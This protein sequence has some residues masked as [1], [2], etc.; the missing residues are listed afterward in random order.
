MGSKSR[1]RAATFAALTL[2][3]VMSACAAEE[4]AAPEAPEEAAVTTAATDRRYGRG[5]L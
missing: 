4:E 5:C 2:A 1:L 3:L